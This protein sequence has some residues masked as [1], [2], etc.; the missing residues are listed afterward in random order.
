M[1][2]LYTSVLQRY[3]LMLVFL[4]S[5]LV[6]RSSCKKQYFKWLQETRMRSEISTQTDKNLRQLERLY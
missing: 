5:L 1:M 3:L 6:S 4:S 2:L